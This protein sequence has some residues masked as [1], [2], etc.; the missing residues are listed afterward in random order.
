M[1]KDDAITAGVKA[2]DFHSF[3]HS[4]QSIKPHEIRFT[5]HSCLKINAAGEHM[6][7]IFETSKGAFNVIR[8]KKDA[9]N[10]ICSTFRTKCTEYGVGDPRRPLSSG[11]DV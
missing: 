4:K 3:V 7:H 1:D 2:A 9:L 8:K 6:I 11:N 10:V 5:G